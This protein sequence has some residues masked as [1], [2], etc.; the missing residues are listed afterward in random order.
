MGA[1][2]QPW[3]YGLFSKIRGTIL[4]APIIRIIIFG[5]RNGVPF[6]LGNYHM[7]C[8][9]IRTLIRGRLKAQNHVTLGIEGLRI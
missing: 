8:S 1:V 3:T 7:G 4:G 6:M 2:Q 5:G 9:K